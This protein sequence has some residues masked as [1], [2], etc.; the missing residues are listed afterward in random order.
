MQLAARALRHISA[1]QFLCIMEMGT[2]RQRKEIMAMTPLQHSTL[3]TRILIA[4]D[5]LS[6]VSFVER[7]GG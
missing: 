2:G 3:F 1:E 5:F 6:F 7:L 4:N